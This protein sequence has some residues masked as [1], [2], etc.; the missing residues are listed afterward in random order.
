VAGGQGHVRRRGVRTWGVWAAGV[1]FA[2]HWY[3]A[4]APIDGGGWRQRWRGSGGWGGGVGGGGGGGG[5]LGLCAS[6]GVRHSVARSGYVPGKVSSREGLQ[7]RL[8]V[9]W[10]L[11]SRATP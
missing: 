5:H 7:G 6:R 9:R 4:S 8:S 2:A 11:L 1:P 3:F 10:Q